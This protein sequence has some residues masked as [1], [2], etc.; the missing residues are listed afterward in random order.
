[1]LTKPKVEHQNQ[2]DERLDRADQQVNPH[3]SGETA[4]LARIYQTL[5][6]EPRVELRAPSKI[7]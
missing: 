5:I 7:P 6:R 2:N 3:K 4:P 1:V